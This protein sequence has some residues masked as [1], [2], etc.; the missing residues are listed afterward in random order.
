MFVTELFNTIVSFLTLGGV[1]VDIIAVLSVF[2]L[3][4]LV[5]KA[6]QFMRFRVARPRRARHAVGMWRRGR[7]AEAIDM[8]ANPKGATEEAVALAFKLKSTGHCSRQDI[9]EEVTRVATERL[10][11]LQWGFR[12]LD[13]IAQIGPLLGLFG[14]VLGM[15]SAFQRLQE[16]GNAVDPSILA[17]GIWVALLTT[18]AGLA[19]AM[20]V[21]I[22]LT[23]F[24]TRLENE[25]VAL[26]TLTSQVL[27]GLPE[28]MVTSEG[29]T[30]LAAGQGRAAHAH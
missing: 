22:L 14:T 6:L 23:F 17:G 13:A 15:I 4:L 12:A 30:F 10:H 19:V 29:A 8:L 20:P 21:S 26:E 5:L 16:A 11:D 28:E 3:A 2:A 1:V 9:E 25:R 27:V 7:H 18:A 24:E